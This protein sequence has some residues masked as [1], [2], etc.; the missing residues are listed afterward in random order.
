MSTFIFD[1]SLCAWVQNVEIEADNYEDA[2]DILK[3]MSLCEIAREGYEKD[4]QLEDID[5]EEE[6]RSYE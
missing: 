6:D 4:L 2:L 5:C 1:F 3:G